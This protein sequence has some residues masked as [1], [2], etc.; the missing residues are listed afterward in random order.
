MRLALLLLF[1]FLPLA[2]YSFDEKDC[3]PSLTLP[4]LDP[5]FQQLG[6]K[7]TAS[8]AIDIDLCEFQR[9][10]EMGLSYSFKK[11]E[12]CEG[13]ASR[14]LLSKKC[15]SLSDKEFL[16]LRDYT[17]PYYQCM[18]GYL[19]QKDYQSPVIEA[20]IHYVEMA[21]KKLP[22]YQGFVARGATLNSKIR[23]LHQVGKIIVNDGF[24]STSTAG[25][26]SGADNFLI[27]S[28][29]AKMIMSISQL[30]MEHET[31]Y[32][33]GAKFE[34]LEKISLGEYYFYI[35][36]EVVDDKPISPQE[37][38]KILDEAN[39]FKYSSLEKIESVYAEAE[40]RDFDFW[41]CGPDKK[42][43]K[44]VKQLEL[45]LMIIPNPNTIK[46]EDL[47]REPQY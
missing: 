41:E 26:F 3:E 46:A 33:P 44:T 29:N 13:R 23:D 47:P 5:D 38:K 42:L 35:M 37:K 36:A 21:L 22:S 7:L 10:C 16:A 12:A 31:L 25:G 11:A 6:L 18:N 20:Y 2:S 4:K 32:P 1:I 8:K 24:T 14:D 40:D 9:A 19:R 39:K 27:Y 28:K 34:V 30:Q 45:P 15:S 17:G 43:P